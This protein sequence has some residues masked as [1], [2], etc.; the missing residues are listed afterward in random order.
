MALIFNERKATQAAA[1]FLELSGGSM[2][3]MSLIKHLYLLDREALLRWGRLVSC[4]QFYEM[5]LGPVLSRVDNLITEMAT[6]EESQFWTKFISVPSEWSVKLI[7]DAGKDELSE[8]EEELIE[9]TH[10]LY[11]HYAPFD[12]ADLLHKI[13]PELKG[14]KTGRIPIKIRD[15][16]TAENKSEEEI[17]FI[18]KDLESISHV[19]TFF[20]CPA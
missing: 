4:D 1:R 15:I 10:A 2:N 19:R 3:Y 13:L 16:L 9:E 11:G 6:A 18:E 14:I 20:S 8:A 12:L 5:K 17:E 7:G